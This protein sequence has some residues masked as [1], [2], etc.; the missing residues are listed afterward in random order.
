VLAVSLSGTSVSVTDTSRG[1]VSAG[2]DLADIFQV[3]PGGIDGSGTACKIPIWT[4]SDTIGNSILSA[5]STTATVQGNFCSCALSSTN[6]SCDNYFAGNVGI[7][8]T[9][10]SHKLH[11]RAEADGDYV[12][13]IANTEALQ[14]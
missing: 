9:N 2:R 4:D 1:F 10:P 5:T 14:G 3:E 8:T 12:A 6:A 13:R 7:G 11:V